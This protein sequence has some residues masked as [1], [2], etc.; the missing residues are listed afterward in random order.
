MMEYKGYVATIEYDDSGDLL[1]G[2]VV[3]AAPY[4]IAT[5]VASDVKGLKRE[6]HISVD[7]Y[8]AWCEEDGV[9]PLPPCSRELSLVLDAELHR[10]VANAAASDEMSIDNWIRDVIRREVKKYESKIRSDVGI[11]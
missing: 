4:P 11:G 6:F 1:H 7:D 3:N 5:F 2:E 9:K 10:R 8:L